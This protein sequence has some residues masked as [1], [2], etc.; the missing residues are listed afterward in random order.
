MAEKMMY[1]NLKN[2]TPQK[3]NAINV[4]AVTPIC[5][6]EMAEENKTKRIEI[7]AKVRTRPKKRTSQFSLMTR[8][9][10]DTHFYVTQ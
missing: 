4:N 5:D 6:V 9:R 3:P 10:A 2:M 8:Q 7:E 1:G